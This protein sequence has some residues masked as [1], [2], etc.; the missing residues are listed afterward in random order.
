MAHDP[1]NTYRPNVWLT[2]FTNLVHY[3]HH[4]DQ[5]WLQLL[6]L[7]CGITFNHLFV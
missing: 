7:M 1:L 3:L 4:L 6:Q 5:E 2:L